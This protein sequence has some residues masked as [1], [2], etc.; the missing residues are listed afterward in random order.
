VAT[1]L[2]YPYTYFANHINYVT[3]SHYVDAN[4]M[5][6][7]T[8]GRSITGILHLANKTPIHWYFKKQATAET[9]ICSEFVAAQICVQQAIDLRNTLR[10]SVC[11]SWT[12]PLCLE[13]TNPL[14][15]APCSFMLSF[16]KDI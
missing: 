7:K 12:R 1:A 6:D 8:T 15:I 16:T 3:L 4:F 10:Y 14:L 13:T 5:H 11:Q 2:V 9:A